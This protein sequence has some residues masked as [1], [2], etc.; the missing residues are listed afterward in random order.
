MFNNSNIPF[1]SII[2]THATH[3]YEIGKT[4][5]KN[6][7]CAVVIISG[8]F[9]FFLRRYYFVFILVKISFKRNSVFF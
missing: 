2:T 4:I 9:F 6:V 8:M 7:Y 5:D 1:D 3:A